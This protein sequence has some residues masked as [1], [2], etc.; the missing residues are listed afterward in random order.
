MTQKSLLLRFRKDLQTGSR[1]R[2]THP[3]QL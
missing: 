3:L 1:P 2:R